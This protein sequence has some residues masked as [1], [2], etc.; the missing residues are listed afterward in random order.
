MTADEIA[1][2][3]AEALEEAIAVVRA[4]KSQSDR[5]EA[6]SEERVCDDIEDDIRAL[7]QSPPKEPT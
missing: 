1:R 7:I 4:R 6:I 5:W 3:R 2:I